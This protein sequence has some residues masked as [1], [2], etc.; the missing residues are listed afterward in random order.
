MEGITLVRDNAARGNAVRDNAQLDQTLSDD[1]TTIASMLDFHA[2]A[3][4]RLLI[5][6]RAHRFHFLQP[7]AVDYL[8]VAGNYVTI[9]LGESAFITRATLKRL[10][11]MLAE[12]FIRIDRSRLV[13]MRR[14]DYVER[15]E[16]GRLLFKLLDGQQLVSSRERAG[17][18]AKML[19]GGMR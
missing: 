3:L 4:P 18:I 10:A 9:H 5:G 12:D 14:I 2:R 8:E 15:L 11:Q 19:Q 13:N 1:R 6:E 7:Q 16:S 17:H